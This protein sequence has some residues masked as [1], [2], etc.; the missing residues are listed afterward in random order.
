[1]LSSISEFRCQ[2]IHGWQIG[3]I[4]KL[5]NVESP[6]QMFKKIPNQTHIVNFIL[7]LRNTQSV[8]ICVAPVSNPL[9]IISPF[10]SHGISQSWGVLREVSHFFCHLFT[11]SG[12]QLWHL[13]HTSLAEI[14]MREQHLSDIR[15][16]SLTPA[17][18]FSPLRHPF[19]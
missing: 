15:W 11:L 9:F 17:Q 1:M 8:N 12:F 19:Q 6:E 7:I 13:S 18:I 4:F 14:A 10:V 2:L 16:T 3:Y 5:H